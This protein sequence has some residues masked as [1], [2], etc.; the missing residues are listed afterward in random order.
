[1]LL[2]WCDFLA[3]DC[4]RMASQQSRQKADE[5]IRVVDRIAFQVSLKLEPT[6][7]IDPIHHIVHL[8]SG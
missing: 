1:M 4:A 2:G 3:Q 8:V 7:L 6:G 5:L